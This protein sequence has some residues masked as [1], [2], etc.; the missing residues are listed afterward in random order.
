MERT[1]VAAD[2]PQAPSASA[3]KAVARAE[4]R[5]LAAALRKTKSGQ[6]VHGARRQIKRLRSLMRLLRTPT[7]EEAFQAT[8]EALRNAADVLAGQRRAEALVAAAGRLGRGRHA[9]GSWRQIAEAHR[10]AHVAGPA[11]ESGP[12][13]AGKAIK[14]A[15]AIVGGL[16]MKPGATPDIGKAFL[17]TYRKARKSLDH[18]FS[19]GDAED[20]HTARKHV[21][22]HIHHLD[23]LR[24]HLVHPARRIAALEKLREALGDLN[25]LDELSQLAAGGKESLPETAARAMAKRR[26]MLL[27]RAEKAAG[28]LFRHKPKAF[29][30]RIGTVWT[31]AEA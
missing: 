11:A 1:A 18:G 23:L 24:A 9:D 16:R 17:A 31:L 6:S 19:S 13:A 26:A 5:S 10:D 28:R 12:E 21:I 3:L 15:A 30:K 22:H 25:D 4:L 7:G 14:A 2:I 29:Q 20:L 27:K 8:N